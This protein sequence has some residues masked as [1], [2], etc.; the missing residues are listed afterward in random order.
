MER[1]HHDNYPVVARINFGLHEEAGDWFVIAGQV[2]TSF[3]EIL[4]A[5]GV[6]LP[7]APEV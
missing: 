4:D 3:D 2:D 7:S 5:A 1:E 6:D